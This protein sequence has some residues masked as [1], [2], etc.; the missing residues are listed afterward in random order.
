MGLEVVSQ[1]GDF[2][3]IDIALN[4]LET[5]ELVIKWSTNL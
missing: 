3:F 4:T 2:F 5:E 1:P